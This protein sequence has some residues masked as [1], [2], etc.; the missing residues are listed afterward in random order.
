MGK[1][2]TME[3]IKVAADF[4]EQFPVSYL[5]QFNQSPKL[6]F[7]KLKPQCSKSATLNQ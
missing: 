4:L 2:G 6:T 5:T 7:S 1:K 3:E